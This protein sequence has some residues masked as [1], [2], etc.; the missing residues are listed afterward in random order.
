MSENIKQPA[1]RAELAGRWIAALVLGLWLVWGSVACELAQ[2]SGPDPET[3]GNRDWT[4]AVKAN[5]DRPAAAPTR[6]TNPEATVATAAGPIV[7]DKPVDDPAVQKTLEEL[8]PQFPGSAAARVK[9]K[10]ESG[11]PGGASRER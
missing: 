5:K 1:R 8:L 7:V 11:D 3:A 4:P 6:R 10:E 9:V 2:S